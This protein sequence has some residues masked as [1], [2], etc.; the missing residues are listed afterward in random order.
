M[1]NLFLLRI[2]CAVSWLYLQDYTG[3]RRQQNIKLT[4]KQQ[5]FTAETRCLPTVY[6]FIF[7]TRSV[8][9]NQSTAETF[10]L[11][12]NVHVL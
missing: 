6:C 9:W 4:N 12:Q 2:N 3:M 5:D 8:C 1:H 11:F 10:I 7:D